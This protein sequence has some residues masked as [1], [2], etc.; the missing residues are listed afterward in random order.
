M[1]HFPF[2]FF[3][4]Q[5]S[6]IYT[7]DKLFSNSLQSI[8]QRLMY[9]F[10]C[11]KVYTLLFKQVYCRNFREVFLFFLVIHSYLSSLF[12]LCC[13]NAKPDVTFPAKK[14]GLKL[15][16][17]VLVLS[18]SEVKIHVLKKTKGMYRPVDFLKARLQF[19]P[20]RWSGN[21]TNRLAT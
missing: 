9:R 19:L 12:T 8:N 20:F 16:A 4:K 14:S 1:Y 5:T 21:R 10:L 13:G 17:F 2:L 11:Y 18:W 7:V 3:S 6:N 15:Y